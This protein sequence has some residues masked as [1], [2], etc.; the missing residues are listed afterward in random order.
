MAMPFSLAVSRVTLTISLILSRFH[1]P[2]EDTSP[3][4]V[5]LCFR[6]VACL[7]LF[8]ASFLE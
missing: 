2:V 5:F 7:S 8:H 1:D 6:L 4:G 3:F